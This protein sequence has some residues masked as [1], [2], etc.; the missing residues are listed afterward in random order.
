MSFERWIRRSALVGG[1]GLLLSNSALTTAQAQTATQQ[2]DRASTANPYTH[3][4]RGWEV[5][6]RPTGTLL[7]GGSTDQPQL[8]LWELPSLKPL[9]TFGSHSE[10]IES[11]V[12]SPDGS[13][14]A[15]GSRDRTI[16]IWD[17]EQAIELHALT[18]H[19][20]WV[21]DLAWSPDGKRLA[22]A[23]Y[24]GSVKLWDPQQGRLLSTLQASSLP[25]LAVTWNSDGTL[26]AAAGRE[27]PIWIWDSE[28]LAPRKTLTGHATGV[29]CLRFI[30][31]DKLASGGWDKLVKIWAAG[32]GRQLLE[33]G[34]HRGSVH[35][36]AVSSDG[37]ELASVSTDGSLI[38]WDCASGVLVHRI[39]GKS[40][41]MRSL[42][43]SPDGRYLVA[44]EWRRALL[45]LFDTA[46]WKEVASAPG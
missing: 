42:D 9:R 18:G 36:L 22:S 8:R 20:G 21:W 13:L 43:W 40:E 14:L 29:A 5:A 23:S 28:S 39:Y 6:F 34:G 35:E 41:G 15:S 11:L 3:W 19:D 10:S 26:L 33:L 27:G 12:W 17:A 25:V 30:G 4:N 16:K 32:A 38:I 1:L 44:V 2:Q 37:S 24:D 45:R 31:A 46:E 7:A